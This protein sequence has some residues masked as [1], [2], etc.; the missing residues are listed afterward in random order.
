VPAINWVV[1]API[2][3]GTALSGTQLDA[4]SPLGGAFNYS[5]ALGTVLAGGP[6]TLSVTF[7]PVDTTDYTTATTT[8]QLT[9]NPTSQTISFPT[10]TGT[11][12]ALTSLPLSAT[13]S[14]GLA[15][16]F[17]SSTPSICTVSGT[18]ASLLTP[19]TCI[20]H[21]SQT[22]NPSYT[23]AAMVSQGFYVHPASQTIT[24]P[25]ITGAWYALSQITL[26]ATASSGLAVSFATTTPTVCSVAGN[27]ASLLIAG[28]C[29]L[30]ATQ[31]GSTVYAAA[32]PVTQVVAAHL[33]HQS[34]TFTPVTTT[35]YALSQLTL[36]ATS[37]SGLTVA[38]ASATPTVCT[39]SGNTA[40]FLTAG[41]C[42]IHANQA[43]NAT[44]AVA[45][46]IAYG[47][48][49]HPI[50]QTINFTT[51]SGPVYPLTK[52]TL[53][54]TATSGLPVSFASITPTVCTVLGK[55]AS[56]LIAGNC[57]IHALQNGNPDYAAAPIVTQQVVVTPLSQTISWPAITGTQY[58]ASQLTLTATAS[59]G[60]TVAFNSTTPSVCTVA[61][62][63]A[64]LLT[65]GTCILKATQA[66]NAIYAAAPVVQQSVVVHLAPQTITFTAVGGQTVG[67]NVALSATAS[68]GLTVALTSA[69]SSTCTV[70]GTTATL[71]ATGTCVLHAT[72]AGNSTY[73][74]APLV[75]RDITVLAAN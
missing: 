16:T 48:D 5:P 20:L 68:S 4:S 55:T 9:V 27:T 62:A 61:G 73:S 52:V 71:V 64:S 18:T 22:G 44:Y 46:L 32:L 56:L 58:A 72:Q 53:S 28:S 21:A 10:I 35:Q 11:Q 2:T 26:S 7:T 3:Y 70:S 14:S 39:L 75:A 37:S 1:P 24:F 17:T 67:A 30:Q 31:T 38:L 66:G 59:S 19:G 60:L 12:Y 43:G 33:A 49:V 29:I 45:P 23:A 51:V 74:A 57:Y 65:S 47:I 50:I 13:A 41:T 25:T 8:V 69:T 40:S 63:T 6:Q 34:I 36:S 54:A 42:D 15:V